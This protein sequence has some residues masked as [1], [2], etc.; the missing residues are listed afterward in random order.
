MNFYNILLLEQT[1]IV[2]KDC[3]LKNFELF[4]LQLLLQGFSFFWFEPPDIL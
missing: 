4:W 3:K 2:S 1:E